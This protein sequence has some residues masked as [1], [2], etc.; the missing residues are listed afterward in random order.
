M[1]NTFLLALCILLAACEKPPVAPVT[2]EAQ[3]I[4]ES[5]A[6]ANN[7][8]EEATAAIRPQATLAGMTTTPAPVRE[9]IKLD[10][11]IDALTL[12]TWQQTDATP[13]HPSQ[14]YLPDFFQPRPSDP[15]RI[16]VGGRVI[17]DDDEAIPL[18]EA[19]QGAEISIQALID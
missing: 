11:S 18:Q 5:S 13:N 19:I 6:T 9:P 2:L 17:M 3:P 16:T 8:V 14:K 4:V 1:K 10:L 12:E 7:L 15:R